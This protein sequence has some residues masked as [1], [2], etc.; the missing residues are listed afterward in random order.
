M[1]VSVPPE[2]PARTTADNVLLVVGIV[3]TLAFGV[4]MLFFGFV[5]V[6]SRLGPASADPHGYS[7]IFGS[8]FGCM[9]AFATCLVVPLLFPK[10]LRLRAYGWSLLGG[11]LVIIGLFALLMTT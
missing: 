4:P 5:A 11:L 1:N 3:L 9:A 7:I 10:R 8:L 2:R 6:N